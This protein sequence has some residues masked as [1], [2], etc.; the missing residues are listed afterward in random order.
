MTIYPDINDAELVGSGPEAGE[1]A[2]RTAEK[3]LAIGRS[4]SDRE[5]E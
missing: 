4:I 3:L 5:P 2:M 1:L